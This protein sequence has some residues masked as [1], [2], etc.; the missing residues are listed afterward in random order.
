MS[1]NSL[2][3]PLAATLPAFTRN[4]TDQAFELDGMDLPCH[5]TA[6]NG[7]IVT[8]AFDITTNLT[9]PEVTMPIFGAEYVRLPIQI[10]CKGRAIPSDAYLGAISGLGGST[11]PFLQPGNLGALSFFPVGNKNWTPVDGNAVVI[12]GPN[13]VVLRDTQSEAVVTLTPGNIAMTAET[14]ISLMV[15]GMG[16]VITSSGTTIDGKPFLPHEHSGVQT[17]GSPTGG[18]V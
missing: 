4:Q 1:N 13:G 7:A 9:L 14:Q 6:V 12:Y 17:G 18:V 3:T 11:T 15:G 10:G 5:V 8:V 16:I 2:K